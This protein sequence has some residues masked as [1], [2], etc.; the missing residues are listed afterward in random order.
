M[1]DNFIIQR[2]RY[3]WNIFQWYSIHLACLHK[4]GPK[5]DSKYLWSKEIK[6]GLQPYKTVTIIT[7]R[8]TDMEKEKVRLNTVGLGRN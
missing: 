3:I 1:V 5:F 6:S 4:E 8:N 7:N 2:G